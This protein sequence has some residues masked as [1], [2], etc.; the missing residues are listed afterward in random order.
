MAIH[1]HRTESII[2]ASDGKTIGVR[3]FGAEDG[4]E[5]GEAHDERGWICYLCTAAQ[6]TPSGM[7]YADMWAEFLEHEHFAH[8]EFH[9]R[10]H[11]DLLLAAQS[12]GELVASAHEAV[13]L[14]VTHL[15]DSLFNALTGDLDLVVAVYLSAEEAEHARTAYQ[16]LRVLLDELHEHAEG[17]L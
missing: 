4:V 11:G 12:A 2:R 1:T 15:N 9:P 13:A 16:L 8:A 7:T 17:V 5:H 14:A 10:G 6:P 3:L